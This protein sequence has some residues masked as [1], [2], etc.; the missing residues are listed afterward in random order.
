[1]KLYIRYGKWQYTVTFTV[2][3][4]NENL[5][6]SQNHSCSLHLF[7]FGIP[8]YCMWST[9]ESNY[10]SFKEKKLIFYKENTSTF[11]SGGKIHLKILCAVYISW[12]SS[13]PWL[14][15]L[16]TLAIY[17]GHIYTFAF[18]ASL[19]TVIIATKLWTGYQELL[20]AMLRGRKGGK[21][22]F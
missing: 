12:T 7:S 4:K 15:I 9:Y 18:V 14:T 17:P 5:I 10:S 21:D 6:L 2:F 13:L 20:G 22:F 16:S 8:A 11:T 1:M 3:M 19:C